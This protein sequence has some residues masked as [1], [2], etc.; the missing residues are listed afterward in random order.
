MHVHGL[1]PIFAILPYGMRPW[2]G[3]IPY[4]KSKEE[5][6]RID[7]PISVP[8]PITPARG[9]IMVP[10]PCDSFQGPFSGSKTPWST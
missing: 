8:T 1:K 7:P 9:P 10:L 4:K 2:L 6:S 5:G 3:P